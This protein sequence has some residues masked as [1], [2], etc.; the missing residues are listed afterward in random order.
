[1]SDV[2]IIVDYQ[3]DFADG[4]IGSE[5]AVSICEKIENKAKSFLEKGGVVFCTM[6]THGEDYMST[7]EGKKLPVPH[8][9][10]GTD[11]VRLF[12]RLEAIVNEN[13]RAFTIAKDRFGSPDLPEAIRERLGDTPQSIEICG[14]VTDI[15]VISNAVM[16]KSAFPEAEI[17]IDA[18]CCSGTSPEMH[19]KALD[20]MQ[21]M[22]MTVINRN[23]QKPFSAA[24]TAERIINRIRDIKEKTKARGFVIGISGGKDSSVA[25]ALLAK[26]CGKDSVLGVMMPNGVQSDIEYSKDLC[27]FLGIPNITV[28]IEQAYKG[29]ISAL[30]QEPNKQTKTNIAPRIRMT[31]LYAAAQDRGYLVCGT[32]NAS[33]K[34]IGYFT[35]WGDGANDFNPIGSLTTE[36]VIA[37]GEYLGLPQK[38]TRKPPTDGLCG[39][40]DEENIG[41]TYETL[42][43]YMKTG[44]CPDAE[45]KA[46]I[47]RMHAVSEHKRIPIPV[48]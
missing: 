26:S 4:A 41:F 44:E 48:F 24:E 33:E 12:G 47:D 20:T 17:T 42:N 16:L 9:I 21:S 45:A 34:Y 38:L 32:G 25:A 28:N 15:C 23:E 3:K 37:V 36:E 40:T 31:V 14:V 27:E 8:C 39:K 1:M 5:R 19:E 11:G 2:L 10:K 46:K 29:L 18:S 6:D 7:Q 22:Q 13:E 30:D 43:R 35:K